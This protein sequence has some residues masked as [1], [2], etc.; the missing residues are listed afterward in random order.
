MGEGERALMALFMAFLFRPPSLRFGSVGVRVK[1]LL[2]FFSALLM[3]LTAFFNLRFSF[4]VGSRPN[5]IDV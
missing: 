2:A 5:T 3:R 1:V 4:F